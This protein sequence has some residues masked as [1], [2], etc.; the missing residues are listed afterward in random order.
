MV[1]RKPRAFVLL[2]AACLGPQ[3]S[4]ADLAEVTQLFRT[5]KYAECAAAAEKAVA[6]N[7][8]SENY[9]VLKLWSGWSLAAMPTL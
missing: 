3:A 5:G 7:D 1:S 4:G 6:E 2:L 9:R 8:F